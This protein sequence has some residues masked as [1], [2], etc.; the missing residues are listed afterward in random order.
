MNH[1]DLCS[2]IG[3]F[4]LGLEKAGFKT[5]QFVEIDKFCQQ[6]LKKHWPDVPCHDDLKTFN[7]KQ[8]D[9]RLDILTAGYP[10]QPFSNAGKRKGEKDERHL[11]PEVRRVIR[12]SRPRWIICEN[13]EGHVR[14]GLNTV[15]KEMESEDYA[16][17]TFIIPASGIGA[18]HQRKRVWIV[19]HANS[20]RCLHSKSEKHSAEERLDAQRFIS[21]ACA[22]VADSDSKRLSRPTRP[23]LRS[24]QQAAFTPL[25]CKPSGTNAKVWR[26]WETEPSLGRVVN[27]LSKELDDIRK[28]EIT[29]FG[30]AVVPQ[31]PYLIG[32]TIIEYE[33]V[34]CTD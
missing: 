23:K 29:G 30:N 7:G 4:S 15:V 28:L 10:C 1:L 17:W 19:A 14:L 21:T 6:I 13:V 3:G 8:Y 24:F 26:D 5:I 20:E 27:G 9:G 34:K 16:V 11:W 2:G 12:E 32:K 18:R 31:L 33:R 22:N 25:G